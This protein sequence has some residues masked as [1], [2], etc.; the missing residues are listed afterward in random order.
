MRSHHGSGA[1]AS[2]GRENHDARVRSIFEGNCRCL[3][4]WELEAVADI[5]TRSEAT[6]EPHEAQLLAIFEQHVTVQ[7]CPDCSELFEAICLVQTAAERAMDRTA[8][9]G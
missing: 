2:Q 1:A 7:Q 8:P 3:G 6:L 4:S 5:R 9:G